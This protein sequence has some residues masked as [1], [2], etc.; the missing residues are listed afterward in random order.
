MT[1]ILGLY[2]ILGGLSEQ[3]PEVALHGQSIMGDARSA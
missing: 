2:S 3:I 1:F